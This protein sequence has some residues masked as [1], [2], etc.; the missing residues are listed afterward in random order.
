ME[1]FASDVQ[2]ILTELDESERQADDLISVNF[3][4]K[5]WFC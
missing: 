2:A 5:I 3:S 4:A 1:S